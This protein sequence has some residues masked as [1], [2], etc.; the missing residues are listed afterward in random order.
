M[1]LEGKVA[2]ITGAGQGIGRAIAIAFAKEGAKIALA[3][4]TESALNE[5]VEEIARVGSEA[6]AVKTDVSNIADVENLFASAVAR[7]GQVDILVNNAGVSRPAMLHKMTQE[8]WDEVIDIHLKGTFNCMQV[9]AKNMI[10]RKSGKIINVTSSAGLVG[11]I[12]QV[13][14]SAAK[15]G[16][17]GLTK[18]GAKELGK[19]NINV[20]CVSPMAATTMTE[21][22]RTQPGLAEVYLDRMAL[23]RWAEPEEVAATFIFL[24]SNDSDYVTGQV[25]CVDGGTV[26]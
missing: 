8:Q 10:E 1:K 4:R 24:A 16:I 9:A 22:I 11:T 12:G 5:V 20:N 21:K 2:V 23:R 7:F 15:A 19:H 25:L 3:A 6:I 17:V 26:I 14:Y 13:N 18:S